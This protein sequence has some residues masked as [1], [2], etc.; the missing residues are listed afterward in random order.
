MRHFRNKNYIEPTSQI[1]KINYN[2]FTMDIDK[3]TADAVALAS[4]HY[5]SEDK[6]FSDDTYNFDYGQNFNWSTRQNQIQSQDHQLGETWLESE[7]KQSHLQQTNR[8]GE[9]TLPLDTNGQTYELEALSTDQQD[10][11]LECILHI[12]KWLQEEDDHKTETQTMIIQG[13]AG[14]GKSVLIRTLVTIIK[15]LFNTNESTLVLAPTGSAAFNAGGSTIHH[16]LS[17]P[18]NTDQYELQENRLKTIKS[19][20]SRLVALIIDERSLL[21]SSLLAATEMHI[22]NGVYKGQNSSKLWGGVP[23]ILLV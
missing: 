21:S 23:I 19:T 6:L 2:D 9:L 11:I 8:D 22:R 3:N 13:V 17:I 1:D 5:V 10:I 20:L 7:I 18:I 16:G 14:S 12:R 15:R 4:T